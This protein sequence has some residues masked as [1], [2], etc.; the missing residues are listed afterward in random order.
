MS[1]QNVLAPVGTH[2]LWWDS[3]YHYVYY[4][5]QGPIGTN[6][7]LYKGYTHERCMHNVDKLGLDVDDQLLRS[8]GMM[9]K[10]VV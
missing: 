2:Y 3:W 4:E 10:L 7:N 9:C 8:L 6:K 5:I 1:S